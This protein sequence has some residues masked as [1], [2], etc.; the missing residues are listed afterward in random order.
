MH[1]ILGPQRSLPQSARI[2]DGSD[3]AAIEHGFLCHAQASSQRRF[4]AQGEGDA[5]WIVGLRLPPS[6]S[7]QDGAGA[8]VLYVSKPFLQSWAD[9]AEGEDRSGG[10]GRM[11]V[12]EQLAQVLHEL[13]DQGMH[14]RLQLSQ[15]HGDAYGL[16]LEQLVAEALGRTT[17]A[18]LGRPANVRWEGTLV[19]SLQ[20]PE[21]VLAVSLA[22][23]PPGGGP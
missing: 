20:P 5:S 17:H 12:M 18:R 19:K 11:H 9:R 23:A 15:A 16:D 4:A 14:A 6:A 3:P 10:R 1:A 7:S 21:L 22:T 2:P 8:I 13:A